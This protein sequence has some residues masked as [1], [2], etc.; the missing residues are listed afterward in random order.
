MYF[1]ANLPNNFTASLGSVLISVSAVASD[2]KMG[3]EALLRFLTG[4][5]PDT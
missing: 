5:N 4:A 3:R 1:S 2:C